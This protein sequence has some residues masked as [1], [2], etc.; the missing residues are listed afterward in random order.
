MQKR[1]NRWMSLLVVLILLTSG[2][3]TSVLAAE[4]KQDTVSVL[5]LDSTLVVP[6]KTLPLAE[7]ET[8]T[9]ALIEAVGQANLEYTDTSYGPMLTGINGVKAGK[10]QFWAF[11]INGISA[12]VGPDSYVVQNRDKLTYR[13]TDYTKPALSTVSLKVVDDKNKTVADFSS[14]EVIGSPNAFQLLQ[15]ALGN[16]QV[17]FEDTQYGKMI[18]ALKGIKAEGSNFWGFYVDGKMASVGAESYQ[19]QNGNQISFQLES[20]T[21]TT[22]ATPTT[23]TTPTISAEN[24]QTAVNSS[25]AYVL[26]NEVG[27]WQAIA[28]KQAGKEIP[29]NYLAGVKTIVKEKQGKFARITDTER[30]ALGILAAGGDP[31]NVEGYNL[32]EAIYNGNVT[33]QGLNGVAYALVALDSADFAAPASAQ[34]TKEKLISYLTERQNSDGGWAWDESSTSDI[35]TTAMILSALSPFKDQA[36]V[37]EKVSAAVKYLSTQ[38]QASKID[39]SSTAAQVIIALS[40][41]GID[42]NSGDFVKDNSGLVQY[43][44]SFQ[45]KDG[46]FDWQGGDESDEFSSAQGIQALVAYQLFTNGK[47]S[48][49]H[50]KLTADTPTVVTPAVDPIQTSQPAP[51]AT[52]V[53]P[54]VDPIQTSQPASTATV[55]E[56]NNQT[57]YS[58]PSTATNMYNL[59]AL[60]LL[61]IIAGSVFYIRQRKHNA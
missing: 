20:Y 8:A 34:W 25:S 35:D 18:T 36:G 39:N 46:G 43:L 47:A 5:G 61:L 50:F 30:Y 29:K 38:Y 58:L 40:A 51:T 19:L 7:K 2:F 45:N 14:L 10:N 23:P 22:P 59:L 17:G 13:L 21:P 3:Q 55:V 32:I 26:K 60:G 24:L 15:V 31:R 57:G 48:L 53:T 37:K 4:A 11:F 44:L 49:Y 9:E 28:L 27:E 52:V 1:L 16:D 54:A 33:K 12:Q 41:L 42:A 56:T 6:E